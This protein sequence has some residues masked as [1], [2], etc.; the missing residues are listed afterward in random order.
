MKAIDDGLQEINGQRGD[1]ASFDRLEKLINQ[2]AYRLAYWRVAS[3]QINYR[4]FFDIN[5]LATVK[6]EHRD[7]FESSHA[8][9]FELLDRDIVQGLRID[10]PDGLFDPRGYLSQLQEKRFLQLARRQWEAQQLA[11]AA[12][13]AWPATETR[14]RELFRLAKENLASPLARPL[15]VV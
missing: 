8:L 1:A 3:D 6:M 12:A 5:D 15:F 9:V 7:V 2:Q 10:H 11:T 4:R 13:D 14:L